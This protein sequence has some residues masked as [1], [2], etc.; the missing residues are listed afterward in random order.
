LSLHRFL[1]IFHPVLSSDASFH[2]NFYNSISIQGLILSSVKTE[3]NSVF[4]IYREIS[5]RQ[6]FLVKQEKILHRF[7]GAASWQEFC[8]FF[9]ETQLYISV[10]IYRKQKILKE[11]RKIF[12]LFLLVGLSPGL[13]TKK[14]MLG[15]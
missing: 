3:K 7:F 8:K 9:I 14:G 1:N 13:I 6:I 15:S 10:G 12:R 5:N 4:C 11:Y 2:F